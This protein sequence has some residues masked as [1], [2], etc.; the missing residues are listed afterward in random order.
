MATLI[1]NGKIFTVVNGIIENGSI[2]VE[3]SKI[4]KVGKN[5]ECENA[6]V[7]DAKSCWVTP[8]F[9][10]AHSHL[11]LMRDID[12]FPGMPMEGNEHTDPITPHVRAI[13]AIHAQSKVVAIV[14]SAG[15]TTACVLP[16]SSNV[17]GGTGAT[18]KLEG[19]TVEEM[20]Y[21][22]SE[23][24]KM[25]LG[26]NPKNSYGKCDKMPS[27]R[28]G[29]GALLREALLK[30]KNY[31]GKLDAAGEDESKKPNY[32]IKMEALIKVVKGKQRCR[33]HC[34]RSDDIATAIRIAKEFELDFTLEHVTEGYMVKELIN[35]NNITC[36]L[37]PFI[38]GKYKQELW[39]NTLDN[40]SILVKEGI[41]ICL[42][43]DAS[44]NMIYLPM[45]IGLLIKRGLPFQDALKAITIHPAEV[46]NIS[47]RIGSIEVGKDADIAIFDGNPFSNMTTCI[48]T[49]ING[50]VYEN[51]RK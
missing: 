49:I 23:Q 46:L 50:I 21:P 32:D 25:A 13:D 20:L 17:I 12:T 24:M 9:V 40:A 39:N 37:G 36:I 42:T 7:I 26:E 6:E 30:A 19:K 22:D 2:L 16:G 43:E 44:A 34:H 18:L 28:M 41:K 31:L 10:D 5:V 3:G 4:V 15:F 8:G 11:T 38:I 29:N 27:S 1:K 48:K 33:I 45:H 47:D 51:I 14:R 35:Q